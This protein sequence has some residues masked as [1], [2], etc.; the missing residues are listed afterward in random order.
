[1]SRIPLRSFSSWLWVALAL[2]PFALVYALHFSRAGHPT[3]FIQVDMP[4]YVACGRAVFERGN[5]LAYP[6]P[7][8]PS[9]HA[10]AIYAHWLIWLFGFGV[11]ALGLAPGVVFVGLGLV[12]AALLGWLT[13]RLAAQVLDSPRFLGPLFLLTMWGGG[14]LCL[15]RVA[16]NLLAGRAPFDRILAYDPFLGQWFLSWGRNVV[17]PTEA[18]YH[19]VAALALLAALRDRWR[20]ALLAGTAVAATHP[21]TGLH[22]LAILLAWLSLDLARRRDRVSALRWLGGLVPLGLLVLYYGV[23]LESFPE[24]RALRESWELPWTLEPLAMALAYGPIAALAAARLWIDRESLDRRVGFLLT[25]FAVSL[26]LSK[27]EW[28]VD[29]VQPLHF[30]RGFA[31]LPLCLL[32]LPLLQRG[33]V[34]LQRQMAAPL[35]AGVT[36]LWLLVAATDNAAAIGFVLHQGTLGYVLTDDQHAALTWMD[37]QRLSGVLLCSDVRL[38]YLAAALTP[39]RPFVGHPMTTPDAGRRFKQRANWFEGREPQPFLADVDFILIER[40]RQAPLL[41]KTQWTLIYENPT[42]L[43]WARAARS[44]P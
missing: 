38:N 22:L 41:D 26:L 24:H 12:G 6:N 8:D 10:P 33:L 27:H 19:A 35:F 11:T 40:H 39:L 43:L 5:G 30:T 31:W 4:Y 2:L 13:L 36:T 14:A 1:M 20:T 23:F 3:G 37:R 29:P 7:F 25:W 21:W 32:A 17:L 28:L 9:P 44:H 18:V 16:V 42:E 15:A 34:A